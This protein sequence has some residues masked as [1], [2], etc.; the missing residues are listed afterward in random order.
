[1]VLGSL[2]LGGLLHCIDPAS[3]ISLDINLDTLEEPMVTRLPK[4]V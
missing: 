1:M 3:T 2:L 4:K